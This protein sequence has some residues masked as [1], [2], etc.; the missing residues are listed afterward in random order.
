MCRTSLKECS[1]YE[2]F[3]LNLST[4]FREYWMLFIRWWDELLADWC[5]TCVDG[6]IILGLGNDHC[7]EHGVGQWPL[8]CQQSDVCN[9]LATNWL[10]WTQDPGVPCLWSS[11]RLITF[12]WLTTTTTQILGKHELRYW[13]E[14]STLACDLISTMFQTLLILIQQQHCCW[15]GEGSRQKYFLWDNVSY[16]RQEVFYIFK[17]D[18]FCHQTSPI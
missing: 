8:C 2:S 16:G 13:E 10:L 17:I 9:T 5:L 14:G 11:S 7:E 18:S 15:S 12:N 1:S 6:S 3:N 4:G